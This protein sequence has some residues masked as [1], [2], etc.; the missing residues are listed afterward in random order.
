MRFFLDTPYLF[1]L[2]AY[3]I[4]CIGSRDVG[5][6]PVEG[7]TRIDE[8]ELPWSECGIARNAMRVRSRFGKLDCA[9]RAPIIGPRGAVEAVNL[10][11]PLARIS[12]WA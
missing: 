4:Q 8:N 11:L 2:I 3:L 6:I 9:K 5:V 12:A 1:Y 10:C 7:T